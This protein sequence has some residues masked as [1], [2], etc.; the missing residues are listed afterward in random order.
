MSEDHANLSTSVF[1]P[2]PKSTET[3]KRKLSVFKCRVCEA[4]TE[5]SRK[6]GSPVAYPYFLEKSGRGRVCP[7]CGQSDVQKV[8]IGAV[9]KRRWDVAVKARLNQLSVKS[10]Q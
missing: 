9:M 10:Q 4:R 7:A 1:I 8:S 2:F 3:F 5:E 6:R